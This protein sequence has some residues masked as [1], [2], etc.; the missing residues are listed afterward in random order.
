MLEPTLVNLIVLPLGLGLLGFIEP[1]SL[2]SSLLFVKY[3]EGKAAIAQVAQTG[4]FILTRALLIGALGVVAALV[5]AVFL[6]FQ[7]GAWLLLGT[8][9]GLIGVLYLLGKAAALMRTL[10]PSLARLSGTGGPVGLGLLFGL[11]I[12]ACAAPLIFAI[13]GTAALGSGENVVRD[14]FLSLG[15]FGVALSLPIALVVFWSRGRNVLARLAAL[16]SRAPIWT[17]LVFIALGL[18][19]IYFGLFVSVEDWT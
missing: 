8:V 16:S 1:C 18:W 17:G 11:N 10:G 15:L 2:G 12:P 7:K 4:V 3:L 13:L 14:G 5:G 6:E 9:Y 19:S